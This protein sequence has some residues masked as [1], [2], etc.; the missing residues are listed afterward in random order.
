[1]KWL[2]NVPQDCP[3]PSLLSARAA[4]VLFLVFKWVLENRIQALML[5]WQ[6]HYPLS[7]LFSPVLLNTVLLIVQLKD[8]LCD[9]VVKNGS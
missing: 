9:I 8:Q 4:V 7:H 5:V 3:L 1:M 6:A 2:A